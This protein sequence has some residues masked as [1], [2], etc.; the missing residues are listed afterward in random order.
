MEKCQ[1]VAAVA[2]IYQFSKA[3]RWECNLLLEISSAMGI[4]MRLEG[5]YAGLD[6]KYHLSRGIVATYLQS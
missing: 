4:V 6:K 3:I 1:L 2:T 5:A